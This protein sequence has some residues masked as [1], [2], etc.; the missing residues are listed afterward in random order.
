MFILGNIIFLL[1]R[2]TIPVH[3]WFEGISIGFVYK[4]S[5]NDYLRVLYTRKSDSSF[6]GKILLFEYLEDLDS[7]VNEM[8][9]LDGTDYN[10]GIKLESYRQKYLMTKYLYYTYKKWWLERLK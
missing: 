2:G 5:F 1:E 6:V 7:I 8:N 3:L 10:E 9:K 4:E